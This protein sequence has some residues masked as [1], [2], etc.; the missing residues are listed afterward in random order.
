MEKEQSNTE[1]QEANNDI[2]KYPTTKVDIEVDG[3]KLPLEVPMAEVQP[4]DVLLGCDVPL[5]NLIIR[6]MTLESLEKLLWQMHSEKS[7]KEQLEQK[8]V[9]KDMEQVMVVIRTKKKKQ[10]QEEAEQKAKKY[11]LESCQDH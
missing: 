3:Q 5:E 10:L 1:M 7:L 4:V 9:F 2:I 11:S 6:Q 8:M